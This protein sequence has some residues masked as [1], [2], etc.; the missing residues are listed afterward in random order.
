MIPDRRSEECFPSW[1]VVTVC[2]RYL[3]ID[4]HWCLLGPADLLQYCVHICHVSWYNVITHH[5]SDCYPISHLWRPFKAWKCHQFTSPRDRERALHMHSHPELW[6][7][8]VV[9]LSPSLG[10]H[11]RMAAA[12]FLLRGRKWRYRGRTTAVAAAATKIQAHFLTR[13]YF[14]TVKI[15]SIMVTDLITARSIMSYTKV[16]F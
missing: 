2:R 13:P 3:D 12:A 11:V 16:R 4:Y 6:H 8:E 7:R 15:L 9:R 10:L 14:D 1:V 5:N